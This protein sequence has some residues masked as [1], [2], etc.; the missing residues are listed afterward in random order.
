LKLR[1]VI[2]LGL[3]L[4]CTSLCA[5]WP[6]LTESGAA[7]P[8]LQLPD[9][10]GHTYRV[11]QVDAEG[12]ASVEPVPVDAPD[13]LPELDPD[14]PVVNSNIE[15]IT[16]TGKQSNA[17]EEATISTTSFSQEDIH[18]MRIQNIA[19]LAKFT[20]GLEINTAFA[21]SN[22]TLFIRGIGL[23]DYNANSA[24]AVAVYRDGVALNSPVGQLFQLYDVK[25]V[26]VL[27]GPQS[28]RYGRNATAGVIAIE[29]NKP[30]GD[31]SSDGSFTYGNYNAVEITGAIGFPIVDDEFS[32]RV[33][34]N[35]NRRDGY[36]RNG[37]AGWDPEANG[38]QVVSRDRIETLYRDL[39]PSDTA[40]TVYRSNGNPFPN[41]AYLY[42]N[43]ELAEDL[44]DQGFDQ[45]IQ[46]NRF[47]IDG[48]RVYIQT[49]VFL[50][51]PG[52]D[53]KCVLNAPGQVWTAAGSNLPNAQPPGSF[54]TFQNNPTLEEFQALKPW[55]NN[56]HDWA[57]RLMLLWQPMEEMEW[58]IT[59]HYGQNLS[60]SRHNQ[61]VSAS[62]GLCSLEKGEICR[63]PEDTL[64]PF[65]AVSP[66]NGWTEILAGEEAVV[67]PGLRPAKQEGGST[68]LFGGT[69][70]ADPFLGWYD[71]D[72]Q[73]FLDVWGATLTGDWY[74]SSFSLHSITGYEASDRLV[75]D[76]G[77][78]SPRRSLRTDW[79]DQTWQISQEF[80]IEGEG[81]RYK[82]DGG[83]FFLY[84]QLEA[85]NKFPA[86]FQQRW[87]QTFA[88]EL[89]AVAPYAS[90]Q[91]DFFNGDNA[92]TAL[93]EL[94]LAGSFRLNYEHKDF[95]LT[96]EITSQAG[97]T[98]GVIH[99]PPFVESWLGPT[100]DVT[101]GWTPL[102]TDGGRL[103]L[104]ARY[105][106]GWKTGHFN[107]GL[108]VNPNFSAD[109]ALLVRG[110]A[111]LR[112]GQRAGFDSDPA[113]S[114][115]RC[116]NHRSLGGY[117]HS[118]DRR[119]GY[120]RRYELA[121]FHLSGLLR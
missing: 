65:Q 99:E 81:D 14:D 15:E 19:D 55:T 118:P 119:S 16:V 83:L 113:A 102:I 48:N 10:P 105:S 87:T 35:Y 112:P 54:Q 46:G 57:A 72:G 51:P 66:N 104:H 20:P 77:D 95:V 37:C 91:Y 89:I 100:G 92:K 108:S 53:R 97:V 62:T 79:S 61:P 44:L 73:E 27:K 75:E 74:L 36:T 33:A 45:S 26:T 38:Q 1:P 109:D 68:P 4:I 71:F 88:Q 114:Q 11:A 7:D 93:E 115:W 70:G 25:N 80:R 76:E 47:D 103:K 82:W 107:A 50:T 13:A 22:P 34:F 121:R 31:L 106:R 101:L 96:S 23:K 12:S 3:V 111:G 5:S 63:S 39:D 64:V 41:P 85:V 120:R 84:E 17:L 117:R 29:S 32:G 9:A 94:Y 24:G 116:T 98:A 6:A 40:V 42:Q 58:L 90:G 30:D 56:V 18:E 8:A 60:D 110:H 49:P 67:I 86:I 28:G 43:K 52:A 59:G 69:S 2:G 21:A 78:A